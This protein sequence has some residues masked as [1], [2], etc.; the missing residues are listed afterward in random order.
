[1]L[2]VFEPFREEYIDRFKKMKVLYLVTQTYAWRDPLDAGDKINILVSDYPDEGYAGVHYHAVK[3]DPYAAI[4]NLGNEKQVAQLKKALTPAS[5]VRLYWVAV[6]DPVAIRKRLGL[7]YKD[8]IRD[9]LAKETDW[10]ISASG[11]LKVDLQLIF[12]ELFLVAKK[13]T[14]C[15]RIKLSSLDVPG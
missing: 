9:Y 14:D 2:N 11:S 7:K 12:G 13:G 15:I 3:N 4:I 8:K 10:R 5:R 6:R 1:M